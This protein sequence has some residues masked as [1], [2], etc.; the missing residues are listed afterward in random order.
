MQVRQYNS[1]LPVQA[2]T[3]PLVGRTLAR[4]AQ[5]DHTPNEGGDVLAVVV[6]RPMALTGSNGSLEMV[7]HRRLKKKQDPRGDD[8]T[9]MNDSL[10]I[11]FLGEGTCT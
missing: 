3:Y 10:L 11:G 2:N 4:P 9:V 8:F 6:E 7:L 5:F 1:S